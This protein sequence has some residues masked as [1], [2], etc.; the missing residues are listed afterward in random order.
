VALELF[1]AHGMEKVSVDEIAAQANVSKVTLYKY[2]GSKDDLYAAVVNMFIDETLAAT[3]K[4]FNS[5]L[6]FLEKLKF[7]LLSKVNTSPLVSWTYLLQVWEKDGQLTENFAQTLQNKVKA[8]IYKL[9]EEGQRTGF[10]DANLSFELFY[11]YSEIFRA[12]LK[13][14]SLDLE[15]TLADKGSIETLVNLHFFG[16]IKKRD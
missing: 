7:A 5:E 14:K 6:D 15:S 4:V 12:G 10:I 1:A 11:L 3:E 9:F 2:F 8:L 16:L 13:A